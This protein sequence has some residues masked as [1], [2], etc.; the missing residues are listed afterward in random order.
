MFLIIFYIAVLEYYRVE[1]CKEGLWSFENKF[2][3]K[4]NY[5]LRN[6]SGIKKILHNALPT[7]MVSMA[8]NGQF[9][10]LD[11]FAQKLIGIVENLPK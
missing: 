11:L 10:I 2:C 9:S 7:V 6:C 1:S 5:T 4:K 8:I 3:R